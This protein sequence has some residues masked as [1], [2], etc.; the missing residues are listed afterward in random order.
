MNHK[1]LYDELREKIEAMIEKKI[2][3]NIR[4][5]KSS[6]SE[7]DKGYDIGYVEALDEILLEITK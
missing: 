3:V 6:D 2:S 7:H 1:C 5:R 4:K